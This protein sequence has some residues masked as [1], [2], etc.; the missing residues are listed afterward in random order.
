MSE[1]INWED[2]SGR[3]KPE[4]RY[5]LYRLCRCG[6]CGGERTVDG[7][8][9]PECRGEGRV[10]ELLAT[11]A[12]PEALGVALV[13]LGREGEFYDDAGDPCPAGILD[14]EG[15][16][17]QKWVLRPWAASPRNRSDAGRVLRAARE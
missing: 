9:C 17:G 6:V 5:R 1:E 16:V 13:T 12:S 3:G 4:E 7:V 8:K 10:R 2:F 14:T 11:A 15:E